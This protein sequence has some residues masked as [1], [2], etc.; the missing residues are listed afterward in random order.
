MVSHHSSSGYKVKLRNCDNQ[1]TMAR[2]V[3][4]VNVE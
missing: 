4:T 3:V 2:E 1:V